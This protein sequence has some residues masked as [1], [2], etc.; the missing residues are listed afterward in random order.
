MN[1]FNAEST[2]VM[3]IP[4]IDSAG[5]CPPPPDV[6]KLLTLSSN[7][8]MTHG[9]FFASLISFFAAADTFVIIALSV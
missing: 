6:L 1:V 4:F 5:K 8:L 9:T 2:I 7:S 3:R